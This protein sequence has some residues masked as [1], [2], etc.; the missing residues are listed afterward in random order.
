[1]KEK[2]M[3][4]FIETKKFSSL[5]DSIKRLERQ[6]T[7]WEKMTH[8]AT[9]GGYVFGELDNHIVK[10]LKPTVTHTADSIIWKFKLDKNQPFDFESDIGIKVNWFDRAHHLEETRYY[11]GT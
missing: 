2:L 8:T 4:H 11:Y 10:T 7:D 1:M 6:V 3:L 9:L 5:K